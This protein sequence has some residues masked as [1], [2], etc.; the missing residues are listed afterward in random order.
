[1][2]C[3]INSEAVIITEMV[4]GCLAFLLIGLLIY[5]CL[6]KLRENKSN[7]LKQYSKSTED[8]KGITLPKL[9]IIVSLVMAVIILMPIILL[10]IEIM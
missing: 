2:F 1:M 4:L 3:A 9:I 8:E 5:A 6:T 10:I 7:L